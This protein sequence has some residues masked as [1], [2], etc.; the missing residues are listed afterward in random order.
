MG[1]CHVFENAPYLV[2]FDGGQ[3]CPNNLYVP[4][5]SEKVVA[6]SSALA[7][8][9]PEQ[10]EQFQLLKIRRDSKK[11]SFS[12][13]V[14]IAALLMMPMNVTLLQWYGKVRK[15]AGHILTKHH[16]PPK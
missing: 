11:G 14:H 2:R 10:G 3:Y 15:N 7:K 4:K 9:A 12:E 1:L 6:T 13:Y 8:K 5:L 16:Q